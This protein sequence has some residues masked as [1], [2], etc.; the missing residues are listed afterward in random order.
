MPTS[1]R[2]ALA[3]PLSTTMLT[4]STVS[5]VSAMSV[6]S[7]TR[8]RPGGDGASARSCSSG[9]SAPARRCTSTSTPASCSAV[10]EISAMPGRKAST[11]PGSSRSAVNTAD[12]TAG[13][14]RSSRVRGRQRMSTGYV[15]PA[16]STIGAGVAE[17]A[18]EAGR[19][20]GGRHGE[21]A[22]V[23]AQ[24]RRRIE[25][26]GEAE[27]G[28]E[29]ALVDLVEDDEPDAW[30]LGIL[31]QAAREDTLG[32][33]FDAGERADAALVPGLVADESA[34]DCPVSVAMRRAAARVARRR[35][36][37]TTIRRPASH[38]SSSRASGTMVVLPAPGG[39]AS[40]AR[41]LPASA[42][43]S[44]SRTSTIGRS[45]SNNALRRAPATRGTGRGR[46]TR[47]CRVGATPSRRRW[48][49]R[50]PARTARSTP[51]RRTAPCR[52][53]GRTRRP[54]A[55]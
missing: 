55:R 51:R 12:T 10:R 26:Q 18:S 6:A 49:R 40:T 19:V 45:G 52:R 13:S 3:S 42:R 47:G 30:Q 16:L 35:G 27:V 17:Q 24:R 20:G 9:P 43:R 38:G 14:I 54:A 4:P 39:A 53:R 48:R 37:S 36:S 5:D 1:K 2:G 41:V 28:G 11:S 22:Q 32:D 25:R 31:L 50:H 34:D 44:S 23:R 21:D 33:H 46:P 15:C 7:T 8:R 29:V